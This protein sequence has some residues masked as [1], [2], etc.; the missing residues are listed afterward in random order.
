MK[1]FLTLF[2]SLALAS[3]FAQHSYDQKTVWVD[4]VYEAMTLEERVGQLFMVAA[5][6]NKGEKHRREIEELIADYHIG[7]L[8]FFQGGPGRHLRLLDHYQSVSKLPLMIGMDAEWGVAMRLD[9]TM[10]YPY[11]MTLGAIRDDDLLYDFGASLGRQCRKLGV[12]FNFAPVVDVNSNPENP[13]INY[14]S[15]GSAPAN[16]ISK[17]IEV[18]RGMQHE[19]VWA[20]A[21]HFPGHGDT[22][23][24]SHKTLPTVSGSRERLNEV[25]LKPFQAAIENDVKSIMVAHLNVPAFD[26]NNRASTLS[27]DIVTGL[28]KEDMGFEGLIFTDALNMKGVSDYYEPGELETMALDAGNDIMLFPE[29][30]AEAS[31]QVK[32][33]ARRNKS[34]FEEKVKK[35]LATKYDLGLYDYQST[36]SKTVLNNLTT[37]EDQALI[38]NLYQRAVTVVQNEG[39]LPVRRLDTLRIATVSIGETYTTPFQYFAGY[40]SQM[41]H[42]NLPY[43]AT[44]DE[45]VE[46]LNLLNQFNLVLVSLHGNHNQRTSN[47]GIDKNIE[48][49]LHQLYDNQLVVT[50]IFAN[51]YAASFLKTGQPLVFGY[52]N[53][54]QAQKAA[55]QVIFGAKTADG[56]LPV[57]VNDTWREGM[58]EI[59]IYIK[60]LGFSH[61]LNAK[62]DADYLANIEDIVREAIQERAM[63]GCQVWAAKNGQVIYHKN[64]GYH[65]YDSI[66]PVTD[67]T[68]YD[69]AS[70]TK[71]AAT[72][73]AVMFLEERNVIQLDKRLVQYLPDV[74]RTNKRNLDLR[75]ILMHE[76]GLMPF[77]PHYK[78]TVND[79]LPSQHYYRPYPESSYVLNVANGLYTHYSMPDSVW[80]WTL[81]S[82]LMKKGL[83][84]S[85]SY[86]YSD[87]GFYL[88]HR[89]AEYQLNQ[90]LDQFMDQN[91]YQPLGMATTTYNPLCK[92]PL[93]RI[94]PTEDDRRFRNTL[95]QGTVH[96]E[97]AALYGGVAGHAGLFSSASDIIKLMQM[98]LQHGYYGGFTYFLPSTISRFAS[99][100]SDDSRRGIGWDMKSREPGRG[101]CSSYA[102]DDS[103]GHSGF[104]GTLVWADPA[105]D[106][107]YIFLS[108][109]VYP[110]MTNNKLITSNIRTRI[111]DILYE[112]IFEYE[113]YRQL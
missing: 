20:C 37:Q 6:S 80:R 44:A 12:H 92:F 64:F 7:G 3:L 66:T 77:I 11:A 32:R 23:Q 26:D 39:I 73:Q 48:D 109:R 85:Y 110:D 49:F 33:W 8:I 15:F 108:N 88:M 31:R 47:Y 58:G 10:R 52:E 97:G 57:D 43:D 99:H 71:V 96:D 35:I 27:P 55:A 21:K 40:Y 105:Y 107:V 89:L 41:T 34:N 9:S 46:L 104:T 53:V 17:S 45:K 16:V 106:L 74:R 84:K 83:F 42:F 22:N 60:R 79:S 67:E 13:V 93:D 91:F 36:D 102:S 98:N 30:V 38:E 72:L 95:I 68:I 111:Q 24:D 70:V 54:Y 82:D 100:Q 63:P 69:L 112:S 28:L 50:S 14:R 62:M 90:P 51:P 101:A 103:F 19:G 75:S 87:I 113:K 29:D 65:T 56:R 94:A 61:P 59:V 18:I 4:S 86:R 78:R 5:Y 1:A 2:F 81:D 25:E 76:A